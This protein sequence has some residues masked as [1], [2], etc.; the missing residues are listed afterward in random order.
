MQSTATMAK[1]ITRN[2]TAMPGGMPVAT[3]ITGVIATIGT[4]VDMLHL[5]WA[6]GTA[7]L[8]L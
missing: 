2:I 3:H 8:V 4:H 1:G 5:A 7:V 6:T